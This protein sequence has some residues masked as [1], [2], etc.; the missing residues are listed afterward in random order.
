MV[1]TERRVCPC[2]SLCEDELLAAYGV[3]KPQ[4]YPEP[5]PV[6]VERATVAAELRERYIEAVRAQGD[7][8]VLEQLRSVERRLTVGGRG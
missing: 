6:F 1:V 3:S 2:R 7:S 8:S 4:V 5:S